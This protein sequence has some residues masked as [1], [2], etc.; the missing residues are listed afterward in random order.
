[1]EFDIK[2][3]KRSKEVKS[4]GVTYP[5]LKETNADTLVLTV[6]T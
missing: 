3:K 4:K 6:K 1:M 5:N 2:T